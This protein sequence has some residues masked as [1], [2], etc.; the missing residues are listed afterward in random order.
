VSEAQHTM[1]SV[2][3]YEV[4]VGRFQYFINN[5][6]LSLPLHAALRSLDFRHSGSIPEGPLFCRATLYAICTI[7]CR[8]VS[9]RLFVISQYC[10]EQL[11]ESSW[12][13][14]WRL[15][16]TY[17]TV[18]DKNVWVPLTRSSA[19]AEGPRDAPCQLKSCQLQQCRNY[20]YDKS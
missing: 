5:L 1:R 20:L 6:V 16:Y 13:L 4:C 7:S 17:L 18:T 14:V 11:D 12:V 2:T 15:S 10:I 8:C 3:V 9:V 19:I